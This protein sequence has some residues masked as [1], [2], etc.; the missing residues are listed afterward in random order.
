MQRR[1]LSRRVTILTYHEIDQAS[2]AA[3]LDFLTRAYSII[4]LAVAVAG[5]VG[6]EEQAALP[7]RPL[8]ITFDDGFASF[9]HQVFPVLQRFQAPATVFLTTGYVGGNDVLW[10]EWIDLAMASG[11]PL[12]DV[13]PP[14]LSALSGRRRRRA[15]M[16]YLKAAPDD[17]RLRLVELI[18]RRTTVTDE[19]AARRRLLAWDQARAMQESGLVSF[20]GHT[21]THPLLARAGLDKQRAEI[22]GCAADLQRE[23]GPAERH[24]AYPN[25]ERA[26]FSTETQALV[27]QAGFAAAVCAERGVCAVGDD[28]FAL[29]R[30]GLDAS[31]SLPE[32]QAK[33]S[34]VWMHL[35]QGG[36]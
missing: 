15:L 3:H 29:R 6:Q 17:E 36:L 26:D 10:F 20:G 7:P 13:L 5:L 27:R 16:R 2:F 23:L 34:G 18:R 12:A 25:G 21:L 8:A 28:L 4:P 19:Q 1:R 32:V 11:A 30:I 24:F 33:L 14:H 9:P 31:F 22:M 35:G